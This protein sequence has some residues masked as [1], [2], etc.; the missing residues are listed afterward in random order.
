M[1][2]AYVGLGGNVG[3][4]AQTI[5][6]AALAIQALHF[7]KEFK[8]SKYYR[9]TPVS[10]IPQDHYVNAVCSF[11]T[12]FGPVELFNELEHISTLLG[13]IPKPKQAPRIID[14]DLLF[15]GERLFDDGNLQ[16]PHPQW[17]NRLFVLIPLLDLTDKILEPTLAGDLLINL[18]E[19]IQN[20]P[21]I[22]QE[23]I[24]PLKEKFYGGKHEATTNS[25]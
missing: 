18:K 6:K 14:L 2:T 17:K 5:T 22:H 19:Y 20:F 1:E 3:N 7:I 25:H 16:V 23:V 4:A 21:N 12:S 13:K 11:K 15:F 8:I 10:S 9:T 24:V